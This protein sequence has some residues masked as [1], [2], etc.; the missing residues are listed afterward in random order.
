MVSN[1][2]PSPSRARI[3]PS[4]VALPLPARRRQASR[5]GKVGEDGHL[6]VSPDGVIARAE[7]E[8]PAGPYASPGASRWTP[9]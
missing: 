5:P 2:V 6:L 4:S 3:L 8:R 7:P 9:R 1:S